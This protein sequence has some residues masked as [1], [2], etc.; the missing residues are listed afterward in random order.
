M[1]LLYSRVQANSSK[2][3]A[4]IGDASL[5]PNHYHWWPERLATRSLSAAGA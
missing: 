4:M 3:F 2:I 5:S 1:L